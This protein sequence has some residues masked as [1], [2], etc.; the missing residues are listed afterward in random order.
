MQPTDQIS[1]E[2]KNMKVSEDTVFAV[3][4]HEQIFHNKVM[5]KMR[6][7]HHLV[8][9]TKSEKSK[10]AESTLIIKNH[11]LIIIISFLSNPPPKT[12]RFLRHSFCR[13][14]GIQ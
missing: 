12:C 1:T 13:V 5:N 2:E 14:G 6:K 3:I 4:E 10:S 7:V 9:K 8:V 11:F